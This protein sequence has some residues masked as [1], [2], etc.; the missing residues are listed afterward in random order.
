MG[1]PSD[2]EH[3]IP[4]PN[5]CV[6]GVTLQSLSSKTSRPIFLS[7]QLVFQEGFQGST[8]N[9]FAVVHGQGAADAIGGISKHATDRA[10]LIMAWT[11]QGISDVRCYEEKSTAVEVFLISADDVAAISSLFFSDNSMILRAPVASVVD[12]S[13]LPATNCGFA[14]PLNPKKVRQSQGF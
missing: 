10:N 2:Y 5:T 1:L 12:D 8:W 14:M 3:A 4:I 13:A 11:S 9:Y 6:S 7:S